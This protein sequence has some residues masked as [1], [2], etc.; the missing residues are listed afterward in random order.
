[1]RTDP[2]IE[3]ANTVGKSSRST[4]NHRAHAFRFPDSG[5]GAWS[6]GNAARFRP[7]WSRPVDEPQA[8][9]LPVPRSRRGE[10]PR[11]DAAARKRPELNR[12]CRPPKT[13]LSG[14][15]CV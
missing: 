3:P 12:F 6:A 11:H 7:R 8:R 9:R 5:P 2:G 15:R 10:R 13:E 14:D 1:M 4:G